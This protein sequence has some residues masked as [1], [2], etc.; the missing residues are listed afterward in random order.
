MD[1]KYRSGRGEQR[2]LNLI[3][4]DINEFYKE[5]NDIKFN[6]GQL[7]RLFRNESNNVFEIILVSLFEGI[8]VDELSSLNMPK[9]TQWEA[10]DNEVRDLNSKGFNRNQIAQIMKVNKE[11]IRQILLGTYNKKAVTKGYYKCQKWDWEK[12][13]NDSCLKFD[14]KVKL[15]KNVNKKEVAFVLGLKDKSLRNLPKLRLKINEYKKSCQQF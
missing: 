2:N 15:L 7:A 14:E 4:K 3:Q 5:T 13:D 8:S 1:K 9:Q 6:K 11:V 10:F 12:I